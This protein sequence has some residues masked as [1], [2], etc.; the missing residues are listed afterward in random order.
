M[1]ET[2]VCKVHKLKSKSYRFMFGFKASNALL[3][4]NI[5]DDDK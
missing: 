5:L 3:S 4:L 1:L 2:I